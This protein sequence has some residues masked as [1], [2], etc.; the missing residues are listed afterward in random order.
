[1]KVICLNLLIQLIW[2]KTCLITELLIEIISRG[3]IIFVSVFAKG[4]IKERYESEVFI[5]SAYLIARVVHLVFPLKRSFNFLGRI[6][7]TKQALQSWNLPAS[8]LFFL[9]QVPGRF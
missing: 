3:E 6:I 8:S 5:C 9:Q 7:K 4:I 2:G 1:M